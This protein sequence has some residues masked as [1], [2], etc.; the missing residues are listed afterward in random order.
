MVQHEVVVVEQEALMVLNNHVVNIKNKWKPLL[1]HS[2]FQWTRPN[3]PLFT[4]TPGIKVPLPINPTQQ[5]T[6][7]IYLLLINF[8][9]SLLRKQTCMQLN[10]RGT[11]PILHHIAVPMSGLPQ[12]ELK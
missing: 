9:T 5:A 4:G 8:L 7:L 2:G 3:V 1:R 10:T 6:F 12:P 11:I